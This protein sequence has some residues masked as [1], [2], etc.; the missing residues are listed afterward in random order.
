MS[1]RAS[2]CGSTRIVGVGSL[3]T[4]A[5]SGSANCD[6]VMFTREVCYPYGIFEVEVATIVV[7]KLPPNLTWALLVFGSGK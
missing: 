6:V 3:V 2:G 5:V 7:V 4:F 1:S